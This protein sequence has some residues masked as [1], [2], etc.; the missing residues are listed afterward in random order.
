MATATKQL[1]A[2]TLM[3]LLKVRSL[4][5]ITVKELVEACH[6]H[7]QTFYYN[8]QD[9]YDLVEWIFSEKASALLPTLTENRQESLRAFFNLM[10]EN[11]TLIL[12][13]Y[14]SLNRMQTEKYLRNWLRPTM[15]AIVR[16]EARGIDISQED[17]DF[18]TNVYVFGLVGV[19]MDWID[20]D[21]EEAV[22]HQFD[23]FLRLVDG[24]LE[25]SIRKFAHS[26]KSE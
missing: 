3:E 9:I 25:N 13:T 1:L 19:A 16:R 4:D 7:R 12:N 18:L 15:S 5:K 6:V 2:D 10:L 17:L 14:F 11:R 20:H 8:F 23:Q 24:S 26:D 21:M 22:P